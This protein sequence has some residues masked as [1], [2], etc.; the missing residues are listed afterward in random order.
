MPELRLMAESVPT[1]TARTADSN[2]AAPPS[3]MVAGRRSTI[4]SL[5][6]WRVRMDR[7]KS[8]CAT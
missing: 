7:P 6:R 8:P 1:D 3:S 5:T 4:A 2:N